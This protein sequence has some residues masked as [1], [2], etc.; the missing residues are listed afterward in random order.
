MNSI[1]L[2]DN[3]PVV[4]WLLKFSTFHTTVEELIKALAQLSLL[5]T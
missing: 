1:K 2:R 3:N 4:R 5:A